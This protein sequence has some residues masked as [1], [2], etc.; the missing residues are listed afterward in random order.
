MENAGWDQL[1]PLGNW[2]KRCEPLPSILKAKLAGHILSFESEEVSLGHPL[3][4]VCCGFHQWAHLR[5]ACSGGARGSAAPH[6]AALLPGAAVRLLAG[7]AAL[8]P[9]AP[10]TTG[11]RG[12]KRALS[13]S[14]LVL[15]GLR[16]F[17]SR[18]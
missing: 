15:G 8:A 17:F 6:A 10:L 16:A 14:P 3:Q 11:V 18:R 7:H 5:L 13:P 12:R 2:P 1:L 4:C 9:P